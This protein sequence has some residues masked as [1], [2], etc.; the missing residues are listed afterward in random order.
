MKS[1]K[2]FTNLF[3]S[4]GFY[5]WLVFLCGLAVAVYNFPTA[6][7]IMCIAL[8]SLILSVVTGNFYKKNIKKFLS[9]ITDNMHHDIKSILGGKLIPLAIIRHDGVVLWSN[10]GFSAIAGTQNTQKIHISELIPSFDLCECINTGTGMFYRVEHNGR[11]YLVDISSNQT[12]NDKF[13]ALHFKDCTEYEKLKTKYNDEKFVCAVILVDNYDDVMMDVTN[14]DKPKVSA[15]IEECLSLWAQSVNGILKKYEKDRFMFYFSNKGLE[16][17]TA[18]R[19]DIL[20]KIRDISV[21]NRLAPTLSIGVGSGGEAMLSNESYAYNALDMALGRG[22]DQAI[23]KHDEKYSFFGGKAQETEKRTKVKARVV[24]EAIKQLL[25]ENDDIIIMGHKG[26]DCDSFGAALGLYRAIK[27]MGKSCKIVLENYNQTVQKMIKNFSEPEY[28][29]LFI[30]KA[31]ANEIISRKT[32][33]FVVDTH[34]KSMLEAPVLLDVSKNVIIIDHH[35]RNADYIPNPLI[36][37][38]EPYASSASELVTEIIQ[39]MGTGVKLT[40]KEAEALYAGIYLDTKNFT[41][42]T[43]VR[44]FEAASFLKKLGVDTISI[45]KLFQIDVNT[46]AKKWEIMES[47]I[48]YKHSISIAKC[49]RNDT[50]MPT[51]V[52]QAADE[53]LNISDI[54]CSFVLCDMGGTVIISARSL[55]TYNIQIIMEKLGGGGHLTIAATQLHDVDLDTAEKMLKDAIDEYFEENK[56]N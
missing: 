25:T 40:K 11:N 29:E 33:V 44:T 34:V 43:G 39:Y 30:N 55:G 8:I 15:A 48:T 54:V 24:A 9:N 45:K 38:H 3:N 52:A 18:Q 49:L 16:T 5:I 35:R 37:Y 7:V 17:F 41:F 4:S 42:K 12:D 46:F 27:S 50:D 23:V 51:I 47:A 6:V 20:E 21:G 28:E 2:F 19:F 53:L 56:I 26:A 32:L 31:Y 14:S 36:S 22:G 10:D 1:R 13:Y